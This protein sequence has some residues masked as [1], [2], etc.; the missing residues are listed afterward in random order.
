MRSY[1]RPTRRDKETN[2][3]ISRI[4][5][6]IVYFI[7]FFSLFIFFVGVDKEAKLNRWIFLS[8]SLGT[9]VFLGPAG[10]ESPIR[11]LDWREIPYS[12]A[13]PSATAAR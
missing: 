1:T 12:A 2:I 5:A 13:A 11:Q 7:N 3:K 6:D 9:L 10:R 4:S 8:L